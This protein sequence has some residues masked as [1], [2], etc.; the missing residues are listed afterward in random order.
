MAFTLMV[1]STREAHAASGNS[2]QVPV[3]IVETDYINGNKDVLKHTLSYDKHGLLVTWKRSDGDKIVY[4]RDKKTGGIKRVVAY[5]GRVINADNTHKLNSKG[6]PLSIRLDTG[7]Y[8]RMTYAKGKLS[9]VRFDNFETYLFY[10]NGLVRK[11]IYNDRSDPSTRSLQKYDKHGNLTYED[12]YV[13]GKWKYECTYNED[14]DLIKHVA[15]KEKK[16]KYFVSSTTNIEYEYNKAGKIIE[17]RETTKYKDDD[18]KNVYKFKFSYNKKGNL[19]KVVCTRKEV[20][21]DGSVG[22][23]RKQTVTFRYKNVK[24][25]KKYRRHLYDRL[26]LVDPKV[27]SNLPSEPY[28]EKLEMVTPLV[29]SL[30][31]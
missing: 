2:Y 28:G 1:V 9:K 26:P 4:T 13:F 5:N 12:S 25:P 10:S 7:Q 11:H 16:G 27:P 17:K 24:V 15:K 22:D 8:Y 20:Y 21:E 19:T 29:T 18:Y 14:G 6:H 23:T 3:Q 31:Y 30:S